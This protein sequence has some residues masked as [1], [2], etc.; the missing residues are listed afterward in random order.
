MIVPKQF[1]KDLKLL[2]PTYRVED[3]EDRVGYFIVKDL[4]LTIKADGGK[5]IFV[6]DPK[7]LRARGPCIVLWVP[8][9]GGQALEQLREMKMRGLELKIFDN[10][11]NELAFYRA[12][13]VKAK[14]KKMELAVDMI[15]EGL[16]EGHRLARKKSFSYGGSKE[17]INGQ[18]HHDEPEPVGPGH[19]GSGESG[20]QSGQGPSRPL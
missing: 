5:T 16:M 15:S 2:D 11:M 3:T 8:D 12:Q 9:L 6:P 20:E 17:N 19:G 18:R 1:A 14:K 4:D 7:M 13:M 10:P